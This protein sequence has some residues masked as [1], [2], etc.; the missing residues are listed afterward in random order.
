MSRFADRD[1]FAAYNGTGPIEMPSGGRIVFRL[2]RRGNR[3]LNHAIHM[4]AVTQ[5]RNHG[6]AG[7]DYYRRK[8]EE[9]MAPKSALRALKR[10]ISDALYA[11]MIN[12]ASRAAHRR[13]EGGPGGQ[14]GNDSASSATGSHPEPA[15][16]TSHSRT[17][18]NSKSSRAYKPTPHRRKPVN[19]PLD[20]TRR[21]SRGLAAR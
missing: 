11:R 4:A 18:T 21:R 3:Q 1:H 2:S 17:A 9:G 19:E 6:T 5:I 14:T 20:T 15:L 16:R 10:K 7:R 12:D 8:I 13:N